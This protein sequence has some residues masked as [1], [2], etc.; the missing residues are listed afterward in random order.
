MKP[1]KRKRKLPAEV[2]ADLRF[3]SENMRLSGFS[4]KITPELVEYALRQ[5]RRHPALV[6]GEAY[7]RR[8][9]AGCTPDQINWLV[10]A[11]DEVQFLLKLSE[12]A[13]EQSVTLRKTVLDRLG[14]GNRS[15]TGAQ[16][17][18]TSKTSSSL[19]CAS[20]LAPRTDA[21]ISRGELVRQKLAAA[22][23]GSLSAD[24]AAHLL[25]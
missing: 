13:I 10:K 21:A 9:L 18:P 15:A 25:G 14:D 12:F 16:M 4:G 8:V 7:V 19:G 5:H 11:T 6:R 22:E 2:E 17:T 24:Q 23:G 20:N 3:V 1:K